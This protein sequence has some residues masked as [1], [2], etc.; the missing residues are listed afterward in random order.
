MIMIMMFICS[1]VGCK[2]SLK[3]IDI[4]RIKIRRLGHGITLQRNILQHQQNQAT[5]NSKRHHFGWVPKALSNL[6]F[7]I[8]YPDL[9]LFYTEKWPS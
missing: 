8:S 5:N 9:T 6:E 7:V 4:D 2:R 1:K 3:K